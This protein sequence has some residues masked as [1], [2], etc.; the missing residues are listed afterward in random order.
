[1]GLFKS[2]KQKNLRPTGEVC[3]SEG[4]LNAADTLLANIRF[5]EVD[6]PVKVICVTSPCP[7]DGKTTVT[8]AL[9]LAMARIGAKVL[10][11]EADLRRLSLRSALGAKAR[12]G[13]HSVLVGDATAEEA[14]VATDD[15]GVYFLDAEAGIPNPEQL[16]NSKRFSQLIDRLRGEFDYVLFDVPPV[17]AFADASIIANKADGVVL[18]LREGCT[19]RKDALYAVEQLQAAGAHMLG[20][21]MNGQDTASQ[22]SYEYYYKYYSEAELAASNEGLRLSPS[23][24]AKS[25]GDMDEVSPRKA[26]VQEPQCPAGPVGAEAPAWVKSAVPEV[27]E[28][29]H[30]KH[31]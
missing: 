11:V 1:M 14:I 7:N 8:I 31:A 9:G 30:S 12:H 18:V 2:R 28:G 21:A 3:H 6:D 23:A 27:R 10:L 15:E 25:F 29:A 26:A 5:S 20:I 24:A 22:G 16:L 19:E 4:V 17:L 13:L